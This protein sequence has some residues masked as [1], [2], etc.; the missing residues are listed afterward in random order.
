MNQHDRT[1][2]CNTPMNHNYVRF[3]GFAVM[4]LTQIASADVRLP[5]LISDNM[6]LQRDLPIP[7]WGWAKPNEKVTVRIGKSSAST[8]AAANGTWSVKLPKLAAGGPYQMTVAGANTLTLC[9]ILIGEVWVSAPASRT[10]PSRL[11]F[12]PAS[13]RV[14]IMKRKLPRPTIRRSG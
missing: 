5:H 11:A 13:N 1:N 4:L 6:V 9:N 7:V 12:I 8:T 14:S 2:L 10:W 3:C